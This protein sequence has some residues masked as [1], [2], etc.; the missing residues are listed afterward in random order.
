MQLTTED[1]LILACVKIYPNVQDIELLDK[2]LPQ[3]SNWELLTK[4]L[5]ERGAAPL[6]FKKLT[7]LSNRNLVPEN[8]RKQLQST[9]YLTLSRT[10]LM[11][12]HFS[13]IANT[14]NAKGIRIIALK[15]IYLSEKLYKDIG[16]RQLSDI[17]LLIDKENAEEALGILTEFGYK[18]Y[19]SLESEFII[20]VKSE[21]IHYTAMILDGVSIELHV[22]L[23]RVIEKYDLKIPEL[24]KNA[25]SVQLNNSNV[26]ALSFTDLLIHLC[27]HTD[28]HFKVDKAQFTGFIDIFNILDVYKDQI[29][30]NLLIETSGNYGCE[31]IVFEYILLISK[32]MNVSIPEWI[33]ERYHT[34]LTK[35]NEQLI[36]NYFSGN[37]AKRSTV[38]FHFKNLREINKTSLRLNYIRDALFPSKAF[39]LNKY[40]IKRPSLYLFYYPYR[41]WIGITGIIR[42]LIGK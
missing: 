26:F 17:D 2:L 4:N 40:Q 24:W 19:D 23:Q 21:S 41:Y 35:Q 7:S 10:M 12:E 15:G 38:P 42:M 36:Y 39:M 6:F 33:I 31:Q 1:K 20:Q 22:R 3:I 9:Y 27:V 29:D 18:P 25:Q 11:Y 8:A 5:I 32:Y 16:L 34:L 30:W 28:K 37:V 13:K 14:F